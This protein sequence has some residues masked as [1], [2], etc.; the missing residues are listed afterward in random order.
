METKA[1]I[2]NKTWYNMNWLNSII[3]SIF[4]FNIEE[5]NDVL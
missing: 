4:Y 5:N 1:V 2:Q 3:V